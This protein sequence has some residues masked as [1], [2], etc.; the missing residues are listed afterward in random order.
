[1]HSA[2]L[3]LL[4]SLPAHAGVARAPA[5]LGRLPLSAASAAAASLPLLPPYLSVADPA[6]GARLAAVLQA[7]QASPTAVAV[8]AQVARA[9]EVR[10]RPVL[11]EVVDMK[12]AG[13]W[14]LD[15]GVLSLRR[16]AMDAPPRENVSTLIH[17]LQH[18]L[19]TR[20]GIPSD[21]LETEL[22]AFVVDFRVGRELGVR[23]SP[24]SHDARAQAAFKEG[25]EPFLGYL[26][27]QYP[28]NAQLHKTRSRAYEAR[29]RAGLEDST[30]EL[31]RLG[32]ERADRE[33]VLA[34]MRA[35]GHPETQLENYRQDSIAPVDAELSTMRRA[36]GWAKADLAI[37]ADPA[38][39]ARARAYARSV[40][41]R[42]RAFQRIFARD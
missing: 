25:L 41:R 4:L 3:A 15:W 5:A 18:L 10:G 34:R 33:R 31:A 35:L 24:G 8:L 6:D 32:A 14:N 11:V 9:A 17:E 21:L 12:E 38:S 30:A 27:A 40:I 39:R 37:F 2:V 13:T 23:P 26:R 29:L 16:G 20:P 28:E 19:Q 36:I 7:A 1:M 22:E 42:A